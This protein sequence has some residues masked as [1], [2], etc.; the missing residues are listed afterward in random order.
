MRA[1]VVA[2]LALLG[3]ASARAQR[4]DRWQVRLNSDA[5][6]W[7]LHL[8]R[9]AGDT[10]VLRHGDSTYS[11]PLSQLDE[12]RL[13]HKS[14]RHQAAEPNRYDGVLGGTDDEVYRLTL[15]SLSERRRIVAQIFQAHPPAPSP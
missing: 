15:Y 12:L 1:I 5:I 4:D 13:V 2:A 3:A 9:L 6:L 11:F 10:L 14:E 7:D 8:V